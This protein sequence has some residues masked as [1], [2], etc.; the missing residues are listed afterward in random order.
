VHLSLGD[1]PAALEAE[2]LARFPKAKAAPSELLSSQALAVVDGHS[3]ELPPLDLR[4]TTF[5]QKVWHALLKIPSGETRSYS[6]LAAM[7]EMPDGN[8][9]VA[10]A[11]GQ[12]SLAVLVPC[13]RVTRANGEL[14]GFRW[15]VERKRKLLEREGAI[16][17]QSELF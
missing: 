12:N 11:C 6:Q 14:A 9:A 4:G 10:S 1:D 3:T 5:Q 2:L 7:L 13:H 8:R 15:G 17:E 16:S